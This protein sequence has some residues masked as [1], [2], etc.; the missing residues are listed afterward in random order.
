MSLNDERYFLGEHNNFLIKYK[1][2]RSEYNY[3][4]TYTKFEVWLDNMNLD[5][6]S[7]NDSPDVTGTIKC[8]G[9]ADI[10]FGS[11]HFCGLTGGCSVEHLDMA[12]KKMY[13]LAGKYTGKK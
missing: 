4:S 8:D 7:L 2:V 11:I 3:D 5:D 13:E 12:L 1:H 9:C 10:H 6:Y